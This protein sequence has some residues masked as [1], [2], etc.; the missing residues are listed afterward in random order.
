M[1]QRHCEEPKATKQSRFTCAC[2][3]GGDC[4]VALR[5]PRNDESHSIL[6]FAAS[7]TA[8]HLSVSAVTNAA[9]SAGVPGLAST[10]SLASTPCTSGA[11][12]LSFAAALSLATIAAGVP[13]G[14]TSPVN[15][16][17]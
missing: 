16:T 13:A 1:P 14:A 11:A 10:A 6:I 2:V 15:D 17:E 5:A 4:F 7:T 12:R 8:R 3:G 9:N